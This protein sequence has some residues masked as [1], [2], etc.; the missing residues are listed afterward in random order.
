MHVLDRCGGIGSTAATTATATTT[1]ATAAVVSNHRGSGD[2]FTGDTDR[3][4]FSFNV[5]AVRNSLSNEHR[6]MAFVT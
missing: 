2:I 4:F 1:T 6:V 5:L 3:C